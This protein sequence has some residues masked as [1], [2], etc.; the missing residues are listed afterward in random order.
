MTVA[1]KAVTQ[2]SYPSRLSYSYFT[3]CSTGGREGLMEAQRYPADY[4]GI[5][6]GS[7]AINRTKFIPSELRP[8]LV[9]LQ[10]NDFLPACKET[11]FANAVTAACADGSGVVENPAAC[12]FNPFTLVGEVTPCGTITKTDAAVMEKIWEGPVVDGKHLWYGLEP[13]SSVLSLAA[14]TSSNGITGRS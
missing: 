13:G 11:A 1:G 7:P 14:T 8:E 10:G 5:V 2:A 4:N 6:S 3:S 9:M 12:H